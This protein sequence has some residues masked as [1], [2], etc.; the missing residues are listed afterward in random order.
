MNTLTNCTFVT[1]ESIFSFP[2]QC[3]TIVHNSSL[4]ACISVRYI[5]VL[6]LLAYLDESILSAVQ[7]SQ[8]VNRPL[9]NHVCCIFSHEALISG[10]SP[11]GGEGTPISHT[12][13][14]TGDKHTISTLLIKPIFS[15]FAH[16]EKHFFSKLVFECLLPYIVW[17]GVCRW[18]RESPT[19]YLTK[20]CKFCD[21]IPG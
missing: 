16:A 14:P 5:H 18:V 15:V 3:K 12:P 21:P 11:G 19:L 1:N 7:T 13:Y 6:F 20:F 9:S 4:H 17:V 2:L 10:Y 8:T